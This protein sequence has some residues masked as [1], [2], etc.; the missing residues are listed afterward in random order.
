METRS[1][2]LQK[3]KL[4]DS[5]LKYVILGGWIKNRELIS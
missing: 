5:S 2:Q 1:S 4:F 3:L